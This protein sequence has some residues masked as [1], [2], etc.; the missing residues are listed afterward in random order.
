MNDDLRKLLKLT[1]GIIQQKNRGILC[2]EID[3]AD[4][5]STLE[6]TNNVEVGNWVQ[7]TK[8]TYKGDI[9]CVLRLKTSGD[10]ALLLVPRLPPLNL[11]EQPSSKK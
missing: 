6:F 3:F 10:V 8:G 4:W 7:V 1:P 11:P 2:E 9:G 5:T